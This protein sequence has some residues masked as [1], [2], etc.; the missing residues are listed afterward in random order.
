M[1]HK[2]SQGVL[3]NKFTK[4][5]VFLYRTPYLPNIPSDAMPCRLS[6]LERVKIMKNVVSNALA[7]S[8]AK[9]GVEVIKTTAVPAADG[10]FAAGSIAYVIVQD[11]TQRIVSPSEL[12][13]I[14]GLK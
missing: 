5:V 14:A 3:E 12:W 6:D 13:D 2:E 9:V 4:G 10:S 7:K 11:D 8:L 1:G